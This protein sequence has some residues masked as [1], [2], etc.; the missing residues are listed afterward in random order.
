M[1]WA[2]VTIESIRGSKRNS[3]VGGP[4]GSELTTKDY[5]EDGVPVIRGS[6]LPVDQIFNDDAFVFVSE[7]KQPA[8]HGLT[9]KGCPPAL[10]G[11]V[12][13]PPL[14]RP[15]THPYYQGDLH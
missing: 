5:V 9:G 7:E 13:P 15:R 14:P 10:P 8:A 2:R 4:F 6:N 3:L 1:R 12:R 11:M